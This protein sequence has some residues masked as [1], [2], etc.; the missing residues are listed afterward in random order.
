MRAGCGAADALGTEDCV[1]SVISRPIGTD[2]A[3]VLAF[4][5]EVL[6]GVASRRTSGVGEGAI[7]DVVLAV[8]ES[9]IGWLDVGNVEEVAAATSASI[10]GVL[11]SAAWAIALVLGC[12]GI[13]GVA[14]LRP[15]RKACWSRPKD[16]ALYGG[17]PS[18]LRLLAASSLSLWI[19]ALAFAVFCSTCARNPG[20]R[21]FGTVLLP[22]LD[23]LEIIF[24]GIP[25]PACRVS[26]RASSAL[27]IGWRTP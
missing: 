26:S 8:V 10:L 5:S 11:D 27:D 14:S 25:R 20:I 19:W 6:A 17:F 7:G 12:L 4:G 16:S 3:P 23:W 22:G 24:T 1:V 13:E 9:R 2:N 21:D 18:A 15:S